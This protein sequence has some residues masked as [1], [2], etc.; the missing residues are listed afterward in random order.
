MD[1][2]RDPPKKTK[3][4][5]YGGIA[6]VGVALITMA[7]SRMEPA[8]PSVER[9]TLW[10]DTVR[11]GEM[12]RQVRGPGTLV[13]EQIR[14][15]S[16]LTAGRVEALPLRPGV[17]VTAETII[18]EMSNPDVQLEAL[19]AQRQL[20]AAEAAL[21]TLRTSLQS[22]RL[23]QESQVATVN[24][25][26]Q[27]A[28]RQAEVQQ[29]LDKRGLTS[30]AERDRAKELADALATRL[31]LER[32]R[33]AVVTNS[34]ERQ[35]ALQEQQVQ[36]MRAVAQFQ[37]DRIASMKVRAGSDGVLQ[38]LPLELGQWVVSGEQL[39]RVAEPGRLK[40]EL[41]IP[42][43]QA[44]DVV[45][46]QP[47]SIDTRNG[48][49]AGRVMRI[50]P[51]AENGTVGV[52]VALEGELPRGARPDLS[53]DGTIEIERLSNVMYVGRPAYGQAESTVG[54][55]K[56]DPDGKTASRV[57]VRLGRS[58]VNTIEVVQGLNVG[59]LV[60]ISDMS[61]WDAQER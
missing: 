54:I 59:D 29:A 28:V 16:A 35:I 22:D 42:E 33:L 20:S 34:I 39:A 38:A 45:P 10:I 12:V 44:K 55:F 48:I 37:Q 4:Y 58:S 13:P 49:I 15:I 50:D 21:V 36:R 27:D 32:E 1:I 43:T 7:L 53:V 51:A 11:R 30:A 40:A 6:I 25:Q 26:Y 5:V 24:Q 60:I 17:T 3:K 56:L 23:N 61:A 57:N 14:Y 31:R 19:E 18:L 52:E 41:R 46:G 9:A 8:A 2:K 47:T